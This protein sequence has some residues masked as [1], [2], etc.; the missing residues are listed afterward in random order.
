MLFIALKL[1]FTWAEVKEGEKGKINLLIFWL[2][3]L[4]I[5]QW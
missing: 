4:P 5:D 1:F 3:D 2:V